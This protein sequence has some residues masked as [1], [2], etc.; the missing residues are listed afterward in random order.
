M[1]T[2]FIGDCSDLSDQLPSKLEIV[3]RIS[4]DTVW[5][6]IGKMKCSNSKIISLVRLTAVDVVEKMPYLALYSYL[7]SRKRLGVVKSNNKA[8]KDFYILPLASQT[9]IPQA[10]LPINGPGKI[11]CYW[12]YYKLRYILYMVDQNK[13]NF[14]QYLCRLRIILYLLHNIIFY[15]ES[16]HDQVFFIHVF[17]PHMKSYMEVFLYSA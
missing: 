4:P 14:L 3:G 8:I 10:L 16:L 15:S 1:K 5:E 12:N 9:P 2:L 11:K 7:S 6:Y 17:R 13:L